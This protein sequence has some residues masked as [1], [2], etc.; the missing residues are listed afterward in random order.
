MF[1]TVYTNNIKQRNGKAA[2]QNLQIN[3]PTE[4]T[5]TEA[6]E[7]I[8]EAFRFFWSNPADRCELLNGTSV[9][10]KV[11]RF[12]VSVFAWRSG[13]I[14]ANVYFNHSLFATAEV[15]EYDA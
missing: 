14:Q 8:F 15:D 2:M 4:I 6:M 3:R 7:A 5:E 11:G 12:E 10:M 1:E 9:S 13:R